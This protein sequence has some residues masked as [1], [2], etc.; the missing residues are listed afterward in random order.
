MALL[1]EALEHGNRWVEIRKKLK[2]RS[3]NSIKNRYNTLYKRHLDKRKM[4]TVADV[5]EALEAAI[6][7][8]GD[9]RAWIRV[10]LEQRKNKGEDLPLKNEPKITLNK[11]VSVLK[12]MDELP[13][14]KS[15]PIVVEKVEISNAK[16]FGQYTCPNLRYI[17]KMKQRKKNFMD[18]TELFINPIT[19]QKVYVSEQ[20]IF[21][22]N[23][24]EILSPLTTLQQIKRNEPAA[25]HMPAGVSQPQ[26]NANKQGTPMFGSELNAN[27]PLAPNCLYAEAE[28]VSNML[29]F[30]S[31]GVYTH[32]VI[33]SH[34]TAFSPLSEY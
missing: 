19:Q 12:Q 4:A 15:R 11:K 16:N 21:L 32:P 34:K 5:N 22:M 3:E 31:H 26:D 29:P 14:N 30:V 9:D 2:G 20:G 7:E 10:L 28:K 6:K 1:K 13:A 24:H 18:N 27:S 8:K 23:S 33:P 17:N 25:L